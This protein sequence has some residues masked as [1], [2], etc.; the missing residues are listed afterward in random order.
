[1]GDLL[2][3]LAEVLSHA[4]LLLDGDEVIVVAVHGSAIPRGG[5]HA[6]SSS[7]LCPGLLDG[8]GGNAS[9]QGSKS[10]RCPAIANS[11]IGCQRG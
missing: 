1:M 5:G 7:V 9:D 6:T 8:G 2:D 11:A 10:S 3:R 4:G